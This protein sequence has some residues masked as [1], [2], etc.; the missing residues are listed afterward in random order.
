MDT[1]FRLADDQGPHGAGRSWRRLAGPCRHDREGASR[2]RRQPPAH[3][4]S[5][6]DTPRRSLRRFP[7]TVVAEILDPIA[8]GLDKDAF[9]TRLQNDIEA[10][11]ARLIAEGRAKM[12]NGG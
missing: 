9:F 7:G 12:G 5:G 2:A 11:T 1:C 3:Y 4:F 10:A 6:R 8:P